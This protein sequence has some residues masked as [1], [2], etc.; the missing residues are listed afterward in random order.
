M[1][2]H[3]SLLPVL[4]HALIFSGLLTLSACLPSASILRNKNYKYVG[5]QFKEDVKA[6]R[7][8]KKVVVIDPHFQVLRENKKF[9]RLELDYQETA[10]K[11][12]YVNERIGLCARLA[13]LDATIVRYDTLVSGDAYK[14]NDLRRLERDVL[15]GIRLL[16]PKDTDLKEM[17][18]SVIKFRMSPLPRFRPE[19][20]HLSR[21]Y[22]TPYFMLMEHTE[23]L[24]AGTQTTSYAL[25]VNVEKAE[26]V[27]LLNREM[28]RPA[29][30]DYFS[31]LL[32]DF[33]R[34]IQKR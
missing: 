26:V 6:L 33:F 19:F 23:V 28:N 8:L 14:L 34:M 10:R 9:R 20:G 24:R 11:N 12:R 5:K 17:M 27:A 16:G 1:K 25:L 13:G 31:A 22:G 4:F 2:F 3:S 7:Q 21:E 32:H 15:A 29:R 18:G 30:Q